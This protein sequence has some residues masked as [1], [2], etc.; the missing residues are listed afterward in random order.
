[1]RFIEYKKR[2]TR[3]P[4]NGEIIYFLFPAIK[5]VKQKKK[6][7]LLR[8]GLTLRCAVEK[9]LPFK[10]M[11]LALALAKAGAKPLQSLP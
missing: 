3:R 4:E 9:R 11:S 10:S 5:F 2:L 6:P 1:M 8:S 7:D